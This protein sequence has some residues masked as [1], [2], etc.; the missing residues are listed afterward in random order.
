MKEGWTHKTLGEITSTINGLWIGKKPPFITIAVIR[1][2]N[3]TKDCKLN[4]SNI[5][6]IDAEER[7]YEKK[8]LLYGDIIIE[9]SGGSENQPVGRPILFNQ[10]GGMFSFSNFTSVIRIKDKNEITPAFL[11]CALYGAYLRG[12]TLK[13]Q[14]KTTG[15]HNL[16]FKAYNKLQIPVPPLTEQQQIVEELD[17]LSS[18]IEKKKAQLKELDYLAQ[19]V[20]YDMFGD[21]VENER[22]WEKRYF[23][24]L[25][26]FKNGI[27]YH[28]DDAGTSIKCIGVGDFKNNAEIRN[29]EEVKTIQV[30]EDV[31]EAYLLKD[32][33]ILIV[34]SNGSKEL[35]GRNMIVYITKEEITYSGFCI[36]CR[37]DKDVILPLFLNRILSD[38]NT[39]R[40]LRQEGQGCNISNINQK[41][42]S[43]LSIIL[44]PFSLQQE[45]AQKI[46]A[47]ESMKVKV[48]QSLKESEMLFN[49]RMDFYFS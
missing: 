10:I 8:K 16:D 48:R 36:R 28:A 42:L 45:F 49:S 20:F 15:I 1:N 40:I 25:A 12:D 14:S 7:Q 30:E 2:T 38:R 27:N 24:E 29:F 37:V 35:V 44:P 46:E 22:G 41:I 34:R 23:S 17:S 21:P 43:S 26:S 5:A 18:I 11:H 19:S 9:K 6:Y 13:M 4:T 3:F 33:D 32:G 31:D 39:M 47:I